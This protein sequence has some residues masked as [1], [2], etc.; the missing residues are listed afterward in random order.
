MRKY[1]ALLILKQEL[2]EDQLKAVTDEVTAIVAREGGTV[3]KVD[4]W[5]QRRL[6]YQIK[7]EDTG[8]YA[9][10]NFV[11]DAAA[12]KELERVMR[13]KDDVLRIKTF[14]MGEA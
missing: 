5:G 11:S 3:T 13:I 9:V 12:V 6:E 10:V 14:V 4:P 7:H 2:D 8:H 1:E